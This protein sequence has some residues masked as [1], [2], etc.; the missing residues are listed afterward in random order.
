M[1]NQTFLSNIWISRRIK[2]LE[3]LNEK[4][5]TIGLPQKG[6]ERDRNLVA[7]LGIPKKG[8]ERQKLGNYFG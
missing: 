2:R 4:I 6:R 1:F 5:K 8:R 7:I 3:R